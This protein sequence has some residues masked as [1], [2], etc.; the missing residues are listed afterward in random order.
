MI[1]SLGTAFGP[2]QPMLETTVDVMGKPGEKELFGNGGSSDEGDSDK[3]G[4]DPMTSQLI[5]P[6][7]SSDMSIY[8]L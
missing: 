8:N 7:L 4:L 6:L 2:A 5:A 1:S 3:E